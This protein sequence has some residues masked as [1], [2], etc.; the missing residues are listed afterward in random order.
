MLVF[1]MESVLATDPNQY[2][3]QMLDFLDIPA[4]AHEG[5]L[6]HS[7]S[8]TPEQAHAF[9]DTLSCYVRDKLA[10]IYAPW[11]DALYIMEPQ[12]E[13]FPP[14]TDVACREASA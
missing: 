5:V 9:A 4:T 7:F 11:N 6:A 12:L 14:V 3:Q 1:N 8:A 10:Q 2:V 13:R